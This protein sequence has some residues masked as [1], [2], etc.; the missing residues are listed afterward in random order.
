VDFAHLIQDLVDV[1]YPQ[2]EKIV[3]VLD[4]LNTHKPA[5]LYEAFA[6]AEARRLMERLEMHYTPKHGSWLHMA[7]ITLSVLAPQC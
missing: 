7:E 3:L 6:P 5:S 2:A 4:N 1:Q